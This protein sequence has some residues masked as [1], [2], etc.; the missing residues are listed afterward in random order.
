MNTADISGKQLS[1]QRDFTMG[2]AE[3]M[4]IPVHPSIAI[5]STQNASMDGFASSKGVTGEQAR[6]IGDERHHGALVLLDI[7]FSSIMENEPNKYN[8][9]FWRWTNVRENFSNVP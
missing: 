3:V 5:G 6:S 4:D 1:D 2:H 9:S 8:M 7:A